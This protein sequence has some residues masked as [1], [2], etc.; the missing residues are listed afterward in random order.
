VVGG[1]NRSY[2]SNYSKSDGTKRWDNYEVS[3]FMY[4]ANEYDHD[5]TGCSLGIDISNYQS[6]KIWHW[7]L[8]PSCS[9]CPTTTET[10]IVS[11]GGAI[12]SAA[13]IFLNSGNNGAYA[14]VHDVTN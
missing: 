6:V 5:V 2:F 10:W 9:Y 11:N 13:N 7:E 3:N 8:E 14:L 4:I 12:M 1:V